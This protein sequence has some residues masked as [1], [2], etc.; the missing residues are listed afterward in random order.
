[1]PARA[2]Q[3][4]SDKLLRI[5]TLQPHMAN[6]LIRLHASQTTLIEQLRHFPKAAHDDGPDALEM[7][8]AIC[9][10]YGG[11]GVGGFRSVPRGAGGRSRR[12]IR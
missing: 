2:V 8:W 9:Q 7:L 10:T 11:S 5:E 6:G 12:M 1:V 4:I 3:P